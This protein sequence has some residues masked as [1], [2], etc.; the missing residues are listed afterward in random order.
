MKL[1]VLGATGGTGQEIV[2]QALQNRH[3]VTVLVRNPQKLTVGG[4]RL[5]VVT[6]SAPDD[7]EALADAVR[8]QDAVISSLGVGSSFKSMGLIGRCAGVIV[9]ALERQS[10]R[11]LIFISAF[12]VGDSRHHVPLVPRLMHRLLLSDVY[13]DKA[14]GEVVVKR[15]ALDWTIVHPTVLTNGPRTGTYRAGHPLEL[16]GVPRISRADVADFVLKQVEDLTHNR[17]T[18]TVSY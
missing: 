17:K 13:T 8:G 9:A 6:G 18:V 7:P 4:D 2:G 14:A 11:R 5:R 10:V 1:L 16:R 15:S 3:D 12:G